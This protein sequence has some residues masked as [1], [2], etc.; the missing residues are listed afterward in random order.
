MLISVCSLYPFA[1]HTRLLGLPW[2]R[3]AF[4]PHLFGGMNL[5]GEWEREGKWMHYN[6]G[7]GL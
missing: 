1:K 2:A 6:E 4:F 3:L 7:C 5:C